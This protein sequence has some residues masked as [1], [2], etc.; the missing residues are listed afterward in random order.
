MAYEELKSLANVVVPLIKAGQSPYQVITNH[1]ELNILEKTLYN[2]IEDG[3]FREFGLLDVDLRI[4][5][6][7]R[8]TKK[9]SNKYKKREDRKYLKGRTYD[10]FINYVNENDNLSIVE[11][12]TVYNNGSTNP[13]M[14]T[15]K[16]RS[17]SF[18]FLIYHEEKTSKAMLK[19]LDL[20]E[21]I[22]GKKLFC[23]EVEV[24]K[25]DRGS[26][27]IDEDGFEKEEDDSRR[28][29]VFYCDPMASSQKGSL[30]NN[31]K[32]I[33]Y[34]R[35]K[36]TDLK[37]LGLNCQEKRISWFHISTLSQKKI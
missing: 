13:F 21:T 14:Q 11:M 12:D 25:T 37:K 18:M 36:E 3:V 10:D 28:T 32:E 17:Y 24:L 33:R 16:F 22:L 23:K 30:E 8:I 9:A 2:Y 6:K 27:F 26:E 34:I 35:P 31:H 4:K 29:R 19:G 1:P 5:T 20:L 7:R 15:F